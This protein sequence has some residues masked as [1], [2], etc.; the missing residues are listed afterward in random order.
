[1]NGLSNSMDVEFCLAA[2]EEALRYGRPEIFNTD[3]GSQFTSQ[4]FTGRLAAES[5]AISMD[6]KARALDNVMIVRSWRTV[7]YENIYL[8]D[9]ATG[10]DCHQGC[11]CT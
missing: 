11:R 5:I 3:Q 4:E 10:A 6:G 9:Y 8:T 7:K 1:M 2:L